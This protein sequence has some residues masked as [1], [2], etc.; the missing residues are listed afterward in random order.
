MDGMNSFI[1]LIKT[2]RV[3]SITVVEATHW[4]EHF[5]LA[6]K[7]YKKSTI[8]RQLQTDNINKISLTAT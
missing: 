2:S 8:L 1:H 3:I 4:V 5:M 7:I 6:S